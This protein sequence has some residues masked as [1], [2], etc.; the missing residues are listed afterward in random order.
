MKKYR[1]TRWGN[2]DAYEV[3]KETAASL[4]YLY[5]D[6]WS[7]RESERKEMKSCD[8]H[9]WFDTWED[10][11]AWLVANAEREVDAARGNLRR[12]HDKLGNAKGM[13]QKAE[14]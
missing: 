2:I 13:K 7:R 8:G 12:A 1:A 11:K 10:A 3:V 6:S 14:V 5:V 4:T 9:S